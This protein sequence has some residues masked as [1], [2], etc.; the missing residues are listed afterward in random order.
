MRCEVNLPA[1]ALPPTVAPCKY[2]ES[3][4]CDFAAER[5]RATE[6]RAVSCRHRSRCRM[7]PR[8]AGSQRGGATLMRCSPSRCT[9]CTLDTCAAQPRRCHDPRPRAHPDGTVGPP[10]QHQ[11]AAHYGNMMS[12]CPPAD[13]E[14]PALT[15]ERGVER[16][17]R[18]PIQQ[19]PQVGRSVRVSEVRAVDDNLRPIHTPLAA[20]PSS[21]SA[22]PCFVLLQLQGRQAGI[23]GFRDPFHQKRQQWLSVVH[24]WLSQA[25]RSL[26]AEN[27]ESQFAQPHRPL[28]RCGRRF[29]GSAY[30]GES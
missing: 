30:T 26:W 1:S 29:R 16:L 2:A 27:E 19:R 17:Q 12:V 7:A 3:P 22:Q 6:R 28:H 18:A 10:P 25:I 8:S 9:C 23:L 21:P 5:S 11:R 13:H 4:W 24:L 20:K 15:H 14:A